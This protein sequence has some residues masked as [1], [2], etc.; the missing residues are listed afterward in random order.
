[1]S[2]TQHCCNPPSI[3]SICNLVLTSGL[4]KPSVLNVCHRGPQ[5]CSTS[6]LSLL[7]P[8]PAFCTTLGCELLLSLSVGNSLSSRCLPLDSQRLYRRPLPVSN[9]LC[10]QTYADGPSGKS[11]AFRFSPSKKKDSTKGTGK[12][13]R[14]HYGALPASALKG[15]ECRYIALPALALNK[16]QVVV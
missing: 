16:S 9:S 14:G 8:L 1:M 12:V 2:S 15:S 7:W 5:P 3:L 11:Y 4:N 6:A 13:S 10:H